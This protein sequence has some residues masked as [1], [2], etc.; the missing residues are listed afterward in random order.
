MDTTAAHRFLFI[1]G[2]PGAGKITV[3]REL[4]RRLG[5]RILW[6]HAI[7]N[8]VQDIVKRKDLRDLMREVLE[9]I[10]K[11]MLAEQKSMVF[12][13][14]SPDRETVERMRAIVAEFPSYRFDVVTLIADEPELIRR[15]IDR[16]DPHRI[17]SEARFRDYMSRS[18]L[19]AP[20]GDDDLVIETTHLTVAEVA[21][22]TCTH[23]DYSAPVP[24]P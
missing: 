9:P 15:S 14:P 23:F 12:V 1:R 13:R 22:R 10:A 18:A 6:L 17:D 21:D 11:F 3:A 5:W 20:L 7:K 8:A 24:S 4:E 16:Q 19:V 2:L